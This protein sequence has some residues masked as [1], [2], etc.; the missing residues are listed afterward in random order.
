MD[1]GHVSENTLY[2][3]I[4]KPRLGFVI[5]TDKGVILNKIETMTKLFTT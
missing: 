2:A 3:K 1:A 4:K 5:L